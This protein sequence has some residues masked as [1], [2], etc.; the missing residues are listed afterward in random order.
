MVLTR[1]YAVLHVLT[2]TQNHVPGTTMRTQTAPPLALRPHHTHQPCQSLLASPAL[3]FGLLENVIYAKSY[4]F[5]AWLFHS[6]QSHAFIHLATH[7]L[8]A[9]SCV[10]NR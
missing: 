3:Q 9:H 4:G 1:V 8:T 6:V 2:H 5:S 10:A 7:T